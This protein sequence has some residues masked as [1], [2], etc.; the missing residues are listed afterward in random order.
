MSQPFLGQ[1]S[2]YSFVFAPKDFAQCNG[3]LLPINQN[4]P[5]FALLGTTYGGDGRVTFGLPDLRSRVPLA[6]GGDIQATLGQKGGESFHTLSIFETPS[7]THPFSASSDVGNA[8]TSSSNLPAAA[9]TGP[10]ATAGQSIPLQSTGTDG[11]SQPHENR[12][13]FLV[14]NFC[15]SLT[16]IFPSQN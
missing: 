10:Y 14:L 9:V 11:G 3:Q 15:I 13:P 12:Q 1:I 6:P 4:Q 8:T 2:L 16:G 7:H 5:L